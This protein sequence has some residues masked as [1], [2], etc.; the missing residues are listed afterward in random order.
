MLHKWKCQRLANRIV[1]N[2]E[3]MRSLRVERAETG[4]D[5]LLDHKLKSLERKHS[6]LLRQLK[7]TADV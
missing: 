1:K 3:A 6:K 4:G 7:E 2:G 5:I